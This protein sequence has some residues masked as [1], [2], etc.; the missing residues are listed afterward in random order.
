V[1]STLTDF[2]TLPDTAASDPATGDVD[3]DTLHTP[4]E[5]APS[6]PV[7][8]DV[9][10]DSLE[11]PVSNPA[12]GGFELKIGTQYKTPLSASGTGD[13]EFDI[14]LATALSASGTG[15]FNFDS[16]PDSTPSHLA[17]VDVTA[18]PPTATPSHPTN[19]GAGTNDLHRELENDHP[20]LENDHLLAL[21]A[22]LSKALM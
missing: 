21:S 7:T 15:T 12:P 18:S 17:Q 4:F 19:T 9:D 2:D 1:L 6:D 8:G 14:L 16:A 20:G 10:L 3:L 11:T 13:F 22:L 5:T